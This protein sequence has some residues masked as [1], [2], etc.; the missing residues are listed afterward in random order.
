M[1]WVVISG[2]WRKINREIEENVRNTVR[3]IV[4]RGDGIVS[5]GALGVDYIATDEALKLDTTAE[6]IKV[7]L[8][9]T[10]GLYAAHYRK[11]ANEGVISEK[12]AEDLIAQ[13]TRLKKIHPQSLIENKDNRIVNEQTYHERNSKVIEA[14]DELVAFHVNK[15]PGVKDTIEKSRQKGIPVK[16]F[17]YTI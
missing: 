16:I 1:K 2:S 10:L 12:Q 4:S 14:A 6:K 9:I 5:G 17:A 13:L 8:P 15:S 3:E 11:R 7:F